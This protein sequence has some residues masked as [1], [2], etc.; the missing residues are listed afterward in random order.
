DFGVSPVGAGMNIG[1]TCSIGPSYKGRICVTTGNGVGEDFQTVAAPKAPSLL[2]LDRD[3]GKVLWSDRSPG[4]NIL[5]SQWSS[6]LLV[7]VSGCA[8][9]IAAQGDG[10][11]R[12]FD[13]L[14]GQLLWKFDGNPKQAT[15]YKP[16]GGGERCFFVATP[17]LYD[18]KVYVGVGQTADEGP[19][20]GHLWCID[21]L[22]AT[23]RGKLNKDHDVSPVQDNFN[24]RARINQDSAL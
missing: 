9:V 23:S 11:V 4:K 13:A 7:E 22:K 2:C 18:N 1:F 21:L 24:P 19:G 20:V 16:G 5:H 3:T 15:R 12:S 6:P 14:T 10:W 17:V 8:Q